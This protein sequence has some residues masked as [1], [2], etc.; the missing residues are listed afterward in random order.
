MNISSCRN[1]PYF[2]LLSTY[3]RKT[4]VRTCIRILYVFTPGAV[5]HTD[6]GKPTF[7]KEPL[8]LFFDIWMGSWDEFRWKLDFSCKLLWHMH[9][10]VCWDTI[11]KL[12]FRIL[13]S[14]GQRLVTVV[15]KRRGRRFGCCKRM[16]FRILFHHEEICFEPKFIKC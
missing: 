11:Q 7:T 10:Q 5:I 15:E 12:V 6:C 3:F 8:L 16:Y 14:I 13:R 9:K 1:H 2:W 4:H